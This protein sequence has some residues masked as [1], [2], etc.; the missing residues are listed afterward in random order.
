[1]KTMVEP[2]YSVA[3]NVFLILPSNEMDQNNPKKFVLAKA[4]SHP[5]DQL[6]EVQSTDPI[7]IKIHNRDGST[8]SMCG[9]GAC[10]VIY[11]AIRNGFELDPNQSLFI[12]KRSYEWRQNNNQISLK[13]PKPTIKAQEMIQ[14]A[15]HCIPATIVSLGN[16][17][18]VI[19]FGVENFQ[20]MEPQN[21]TAER[22][23]QMIAN[24]MAPSLGDI[25]VH[26]VTRE[27]ENLL[28]AI[29]WENGVG[30]TQA[31]GS[32][33]LAIAAA[34]FYRHKPN[35]T[36]KEFQIKMPGGQLSVKISEYNAI[37]TTEPILLSDRQQKKHCKQSR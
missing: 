35:S 36:G 6:L 29:P 10:A 18:L 26:F 37:L 7:T 17:H 11:W 23:G 27:T 32:G 3:G 30:L 21:F 4:K 22:F 8:A 12:G 16:T 1:M 5:F 2:I 24:V 28:K 15:N 25:N 9:N 31:C 19:E 34:D 33:A 14:L 20:W 13:I